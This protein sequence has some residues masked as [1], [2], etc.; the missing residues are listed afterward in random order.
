MRPALLVLLFVVVAAALPRV[1]VLELSFGSMPCDGVVCTKEADANGD[2]GCNFAETQACRMTG[3]S[4]P[5]K[6][7]QDILNELN[8]YSRALRDAI[9]AR[10]AEDYA[11]EPAAKRA[12]K[13]EWSRSVGSDCSPLGGTTN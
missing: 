6:D 8:A 7:F 1:P 13:A 2:G 11:E 3:Y 12:R 10:Y 9:E 4:L 5:H